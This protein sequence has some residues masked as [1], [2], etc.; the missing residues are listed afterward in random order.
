MDHQLINFAVLI[1][2]NITAIIVK[3]CEVQC[4][5]RKITDNISL[6]EFERLHN[7]IDTGLYL[8]DKIR[9]QMIEL[10]THLM[11]TVFYKSSLFKEGQAQ[12]TVG[13]I[14]GVKML[15]QADDFT[16]YFW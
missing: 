9:D 11:F 16:D 7:G 13:H 4:E 10:S 2:Q 3:N 12:N 6:F 14:I 15:Q 5:I 8:G 1:E